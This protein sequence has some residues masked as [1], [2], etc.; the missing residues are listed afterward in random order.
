M[1]YRELNSIAYAQISFEFIKNSETVKYNLYD[2]GT[3]VASI[4][5]GYNLRDDNVRDAVLDALTGNNVPSGLDGEIETIIDQQWSDDLITGTEVSINN[6]MASYSNQNSNVPNTFV[7]TS[8]QQ[9]QNVFDTIIGEYED[10]IDT[11]FQSTY[12]P[13]SYER[14][15]ILSLTYNSP[16]LIGPKLISAIENDNRAEAWYEIRY[17]SNSNSQL[18][19]IQNG[20]AKRRYYESEMFGLYK[21]IHH[22]T[23]KEAR[24]VF[25]TIERHGAFD[26]ENKIVTYDNNFSKMIDGNGTINAN[27]D[28]DVSILQAGQVQTYDE[29]ISYAKEYLIETY[30]SPHEI[31]PTNIYVDF[32]QLLAPFAE[33]NKFTGDYKNDLVL[34][35]DG[36]DRLDGGRGI[37]IVYGEGGDD[38]LVFRQTDSSL[39]YTTKEFL[40]GG[41]GNDTLVIDL[42]SSQLSYELRQE[43]LEVYDQMVLNPSS[44]IFEYT[45]TNLNLEISGFENLEVWVDGKQVSLALNAADA[46]MFP[47]LEGSGG[48]N[49]M[50]GDNIMHASITQLESTYILYN[51]TYSFAELTPATTG[52]FSTNEG[53]SI[54][55][56]ESGEFTY[57]SPSSSYYGE[58]RYN[59]TVTDASGQ[60]SNA[61]VYLYNQELVSEY[62]ESYTA[63]HAVN[64]VDNAILGIDY[65][66]NYDPNLDVYV[67]TRN[68]TN[69]VTGSDHPDFIMTHD[70]DDIIHGGSGNDYL[71]GGGNYQDVSNWN[72]NVADHFFLANSELYGEEGDDIIEI[73]TGN[74]F[75]SGGSGNDLIIRVYPSY[76]HDTH[77]EKGIITIEGNEGNDI[78]RSG[79][80]EEELVYGGSGNDYF[81]HTIRVNTESVNESDLFD[82]G[83]GIDVIKFDLDREFYT[84]SGLEIDLVTQTFEYDS[85]SNTIVN[86]ENVTGSVLDDI[87]SGS[88]TDNIIDGSDGN[89]ELYGFTG[90]DTL[91]GGAGDDEFIIN[92]GEG[93]D[94]IYDTEGNDKIIFGSGILSGDLT[95]IKDGLDLIIKNSGIELVRLADHFSNEDNVDSIKFSDAT[96]VLL[97]NVFQNELEGT[98]ADD[99]VISDEGNIV[100]VI[101]A[102]NG[103]DTVYSAAG[104]DELNGGDGDDIL[105]GGIGN[106]VI[107][108]NDGNDILIGGVGNDILNGGNGFDTADY[109]MAGSSV[110]VSLAA[111]TATGGDGSDTLSNVENI[112]GSYYNDTLSGNTF[113]NIIQGGIGNDTLSGGGSIGDSN[114]TVSYSDAVSAVTVSL[115]TTSAQNTT[116]AGTDTISNFE[117]LI[118]SSYND[119]LT[120]SGSSNTIEGGD[121]DDVMDGGFST[122]TVSY[123]HATAGVTVDL[124]VT[125]SQNTVGAGWDTLISFDNIIGSAYNDTLTGNPSANVIEGGLGDDILTGGASTDTASYASAT[126]G[127][128]VS[129]AISGTQNTG[130]TGTDTLSLFENLLGS[131]YND[132]LTG[133]TGNNVLTGGD[134]NDILEGGA[135][136]DTLVGGNGSDTA[137][138]TV[139]ASA[140]NVNLSTTTSQNTGGAGSDTLTG[141][142]NLTGSAYNDT[143]TGDA[144]ANLINGGNGN[145]TLIGGLGNDTLIG[146]S[147]TDLLTYASSTAGVTVNLNTTLAQSTGSDGVDTISEIE[148]LTGSAYAD[149]LTG[150]SANNVINGGDGNDSI[151]GGAGSDTLVGGLGTD[152]LSYATA[153]AAVAV[154]LATT[155]AQSTGG[156]GTDTVSG[157]E[158][159]A[160]SAFNDT[161]TGDANDNILSGLDGNDTLAGG[162]GNDTLN[163][164]SGIDTA[165]YGAA[166][167][168]VTVDLGNA[169]AQNTSGAGTDTL[170]SIENVTG[171]AFNDTLT[172]DSG[173]NTINGGDGN[174]TLTGGSGDD[175][176]TGGNGTD[177]ASYASAS[178]GVTV[179]LA[180]TTA[181]NTVSAGSD[182]LSSVESL[183]GSA[184]DDVLT[185]DS[186]ANTIDAGAGNDTVEG[187]LGNDILI[188]G[189]GIDWLSFASATSSVTVNLGTLTAQNTGLT[190]SDTI[191]GFENLLGSAFDD[192]I[193]GSGGSNLIEGGAGNDIMDGGASTDTLSYLHATAGVTIDLSVTT[194]QNTGGAGLDT[195]TSFEN[196]IGSAYNDTIT[197]TS[198]ANVIEGGLGND[199]LTGGLSTDTA[200]YASATSGVTVSLALGYQNTGVTG[201]D[202]L[203][204]FENLLGS[205]YNDTL[206]GDTNQNL[207][208]GGAGNDTIDG[209]SSNDTA[210]YETAASGVTVS[211]A[212]SGAQ[213]TIGDGTDILISIERLT[214]SAYDDVL[215][216]NSGLNILKGGLGNDILTSGASA[217]TMQG[218]G[219]ADTFL[220]L[221]AGMGTADTVADFTLAQSDKINIADLLVGYSSGTSNIGDFV[222]ATTSGSNSI[223]AIDRDG[224]GSTY[225]FQNIATLSNITGLDVHDMLTNGHLVAA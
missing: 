44:G 216:G 222:S 110:A 131:A 68:Y 49:L 91:I 162:A 104:N 25:R 165:S 81:F 203:T 72:P 172:G 155:S 183:T 57:T 137:A 9:I 76:N 105:N 3:G 33:M 107:N 2:D 194:Q 220:F 127:V 148:N 86:F 14:T 199:I 92:Q 177:T 20:I 207:I 170:S 62:A 225:S 186:N 78:I 89:D 166:A 87:I 118:G 213:N 30:A 126:S 133:S 8:E 10:S 195:V 117:N 65:E 90:N 161:L 43:I 23:D 146:G 4:G 142:E 46:V 140:V 218:D 61:T 209:G 97:S 202:T 143:L 42:R 182:T 175:T 45:F 79:T 54:T 121:G 178:A 134:G 101:N 151:D 150:S 145:D 201:Y 75:A 53:G 167:T 160:G 114:D 67:S 171:S 138:Y 164:G 99:L 77:F 26:S 64:Y 6:K 173:N 84:V 181:Q 88:S 50:H 184:F 149:V 135:G 66:T 48:G 24:D 51:E 28:Y 120:G 73:G 94:N 124:S 55:I 223:I 156:S 16:S 83:N 130:V 109:S 31:I 136:N 95:Y 70:G 132:T 85:I 13:N 80:D 198:S 15:A 116:S 224:T 103:N 206:T 139:A 169:S 158:N 125:G 98:E 147:G 21:D 159:L 123:A 115:N 106:D 187:G 35:G 27:H 47:A 102:G 208:N 129:L 17:N 144:A 174:D 215:T 193:T 157:F 210:S 219:G 214:G 22:V 12:L 82:G 58:D 205:A 111:G 176:L 29:S 1:D 119:T 212:I 221:T 69:N 60:T 196:V 39:L 71:S 188:G 154:T 11:K 200:S 191:S 152:T 63:T 40:S 192:T 204:S 7:F 108:G 217:D 36:D 185:G 190:G 112:I 100:D 56:Y 93:V 59:F 74:I 122:D 96:T 179:S 38:T 41:D 5:I 52:T 37:D 197:G 168:A 18:E 19:A 211:L 128:T 141:I 163:G 32:G 189:L 180:A 153:S 34:G 113:A